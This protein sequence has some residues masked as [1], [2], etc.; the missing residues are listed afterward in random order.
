MPLFPCR[1]ARNGIYPGVPEE[2][3]PAIG[4]RL[5]TLLTH[6]VFRKEFI[7]PFS[8]FKPAV[9]TTMFRQIRHV[10]SKEFPDIWGIFRAAMQ[11][12]DNNSAT[13]E[14]RANLIIFVLSILARGLDASANCVQEVIGAVLIGSNVK[15]PVWSLPLLCPS[16][17]TSYRCLPRYTIPPS[18]L[19][20]HAP[21][22]PAFLSVWI[23]Y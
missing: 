3:W 19:P 11:P 8:P 17:L 10:I 12:R 9:E 18:P 1:T 20:P 15:A 6:D 5:R 22:P 23:I 7:P 2:S 4:K 16:L 14:W 21:V 13:A